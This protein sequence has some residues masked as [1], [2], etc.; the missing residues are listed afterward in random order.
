MHGVKWKAS[1]FKKCNTAV[2]QISSLQSF[3]S[4]DAQNSEGRQE[5]NSRDTLDVVRPPSDPNCRNSLST[6]RSFVSIL[7]CFTISSA[8]LGQS[9]QCGAN[10][11][12]KN[13]LWFICDKNRKLKINNKALIKEEKSSAQKGFCLLLTDFGKSLVQNRHKLHASYRTLTGANP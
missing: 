11:N 12:W 10:K 7:V 8:H 3:S 13:C 5:V 2:L 1:F 4:D 9:N 6:S